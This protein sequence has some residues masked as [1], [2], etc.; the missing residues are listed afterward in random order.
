MRTRYGF[1]SAPAPKFKNVRTE[2]D[3]LRFDSKK[4][5]A[6][7]VELKRLRAAGE[8]LWFIRQPTFDLPGGIRHRADFLA[9]LAAGGVRVEDVKSRGTRTRVYINKVKQVKAL[10]GVEVTEV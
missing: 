1:R 8:V 4:E 5:A 3:G 7:Y 6:R 9:V 2:V 10:Y